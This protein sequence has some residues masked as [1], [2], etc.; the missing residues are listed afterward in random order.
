MKSKWQQKTVHDKKTVRYWY[1]NMLFFFM[2][3]VR[4]VGAC[5]Y[6]E[7]M[8]IT[9]CILCYITL[10]HC[11]IQSFNSVKYCKEVA[12]AVLGHKIKQID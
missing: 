2:R 4:V 7:V 8:K 5:T 11:Q 10:K 1:S 6:L 3:T 12:V 9:Q